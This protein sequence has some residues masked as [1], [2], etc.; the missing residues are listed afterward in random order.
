MEKNLNTFCMRV[1][2]WYA[3]HFPE[4]NALLP[5]N[6]TYV[7]FV[8]AVGAR[9]NLLTMDPEDLQE[10]AGD[11]DIA[12]QIVERSKSS[13]GND[14]NEID[15]E[16]LKTFAE[17][18]AQH[19]DFKRNLQGYLKTVMSGVAPN[20]T[21]L[22]GETVGAK[23]LTQAGGLLHLAKLPASTIQILGAEKAL[24][25]ALKTKSKTPKYGH[26]YN[27]SFIGKAKLADKGKVSRCLANKCALASR[28][29]SFLVKPTNRFGEVFKRQV[30]ERVDGVVPTVLLNK[31]S[32]K[33]MDALVQELKDDGL[34]FQRKALKTD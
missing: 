16:S 15:E 9:T 21:E 14:L 32:H 24:F 17:Y 6:E 4:L 11:A 19:F 2:E 29:D 30:Q 20:L 25:R 5:D 26:L 31:R 22:L 12:L 8:M 27:S 13:M 23:L 33:E 18:V 28:L 3:W 34:Y 10:L 1:K 7:K